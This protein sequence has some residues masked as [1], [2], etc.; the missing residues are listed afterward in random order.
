M[1]YRL[2]RQT[3]SEVVAMYESGMSGDVVAANFNISC[4]TVFQPATQGV[5]ET[6]TIA[7]AP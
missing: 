1:V 4:W 2:D 6:V 7:G 3:I 5:P